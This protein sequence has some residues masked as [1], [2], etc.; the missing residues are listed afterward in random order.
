MSANL[1]NVI[2]DP[3]GH[4][5]RNPQDLMNHEIVVHE[6]QADRCDVIRQF[7]T[8]GIGKTGKPTHVHPHSEVLTF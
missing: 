6:M 1:P 3:G 2:R 4:R 8:E 5:R 7:L